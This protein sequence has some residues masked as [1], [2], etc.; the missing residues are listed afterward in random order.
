MKEEKALTHKE[1]LIEY[2]KHKAE[3]LT[4]YH[5]LKMDLEYAMD[6]VEEGLLNEKRKKL[7]RQI[8]A[9]SKNI[10]KLVAEE[11]MA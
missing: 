6:S 5:Q 7:S 8:K 11:N 10:K 3:L 9:L 4:A 2:E 1:Q